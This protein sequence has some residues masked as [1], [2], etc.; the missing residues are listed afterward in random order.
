MIHR[1]ELRVT[2]TRGQCFGPYV[3]LGAP[4]RPTIYPSVT[5]SRWGSIEIGDRASVLFLFGM[6]IW[7]RWHKKE[8]K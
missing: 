3:A 4:D 5:R 7:I 6:P 2:M 8:E 1:E